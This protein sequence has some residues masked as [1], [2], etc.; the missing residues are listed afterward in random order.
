[1]ELVIKEGTAAGTGDKRLP[2]PPGL[3][4][5]P[6]GDSDSLSPQERWLKM[7]IPRAAALTQGQ[8]H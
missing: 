6:A 3:M 1:M 8:L 2:C 7:S 5:A 4:A